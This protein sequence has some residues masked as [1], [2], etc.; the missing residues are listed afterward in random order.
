M[1][2]FT[3][4]KAA[5]VAVDI[6]TALN[7]REIVG[8]AYFFANHTPLNALG[9]LMFFPLQGYHAITLGT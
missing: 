4:F 3:W 8:M 2:W 9:A 7:D 5:D 6:F 1:T